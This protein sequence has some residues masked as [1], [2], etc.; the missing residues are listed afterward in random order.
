MSGDVG[1]LPHMTIGALASSDL[2]KDSHEP[3]HVHES[4]IK[5]DLSIAP[6]NLKFLFVNGRRHFGNRQLK[7]EYFEYFCEYFGYLVEIV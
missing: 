3:I 7:T 4:R 1:M 6:D 2:D 5:T